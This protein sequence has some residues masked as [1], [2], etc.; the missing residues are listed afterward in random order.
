MRSAGTDPSLR[1]IS[2]A[3]A[4]R[5]A[6]FGREGSLPRAMGRVAR[7]DQQEIARNPPDP[8]PVAAAH[9]V[10]DLLVGGIG[11][12]GTEKRCSGV[13]RVTRPAAEIACIR[14]SY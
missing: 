10:D 6:A 4:T 14:P 9:E 8:P 7:V 13:A 12:Q 1:M 5:S 3:A 2:T 11:V